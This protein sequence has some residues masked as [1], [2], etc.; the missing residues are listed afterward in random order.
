MSARL[1]R[2]LPFV[3]GAMHA[4]V[5]ASSA[6]VVFAAMRMHGIA[7]REAFCFVVIYDLLAFALQ[8]L[9]GA[10]TDKIRRPRGV[11]MAGLALLSFG[12]L[13]LSFEPYV[14]MVLVGVGNAAFHVGAGAI[15]LRIEPRRAT[16]AGIFVGPG[17]LGLAFGIWFG[18]TGPAMAW[19]FTLGLSIAF[20]ATLFLPDPEHP[21]EMQPE[22]AP[23][24]AQ[25]RAAARTARPWLVVGLLLFSVLVRSVV[26][27]AGS[28]RCPKQVVVIFTL[29]SAA[30]MGKAL[31]GVVSDR[32]G[33]IETSV[34]ALLLSAPLIAFGGSAWWVVAAGMF[35]F[36]MTMPVTLTALSIVFPSRPGL[37]F[38]LA[39]LALIVGALMTFSADV[40]ALYGPWP[41]LAL[42]LL[43]AAS[44]AAGLRLMGDLNPARGVLGRARS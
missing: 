1:A 29:A 24:D 21:Y 34:A 36:Q 4:V 38:G 7:F 42:I 27:M 28:Y 9:I 10:G 17:A 12:T 31:G 26:G 22:P 35:L 3:Y 18:K 41:F 32:L 19:P 11:L 16:H 44:M 23:G 33:W 43:S 39:S 20:V 14:A 6:M 37:A 2:R 15:S 30:M 25:A 8:V 13:A 5:D 40:R